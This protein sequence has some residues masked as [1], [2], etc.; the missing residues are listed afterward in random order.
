MVRSNVWVPVAAPMSR[1]SALFIVMSIVGCIRQPMPTP[2][3]SVRPEATGAV[4]A[5][6]SV[7]RASAPAAA[8]APPAMG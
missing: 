1:G 5:V 3:T 8:S 2:S 7:S 4:V 6:P